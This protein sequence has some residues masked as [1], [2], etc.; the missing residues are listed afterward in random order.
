MTLT[1]LDWGIIGV[2]LLAIIV[3]GLYLSRRAAKSTDSFF[4]GGR[5]MPWWLLGTSMVA[6]TFATDTPNLVTGL[7][8]E[9]GVAG[10]WGWWAFLITGMLTAFVYARLWRR[11][12]IT[13]DIEFYELRYSGRPAAF[14]RGLRAVY[15]GLFFNV[16]VM[17]NVTLALIKYGNVLFGI[18]PVLIVLVA[19]AATVLL[20]AS[21]GLL[22]VLVTDFFLFIISMVGAIAAAWFALHHTD[23]GGLSGLMSNTLVLEKR[24]FLPDFSDPNQYVPLFMVPLLLQWWSAWYPGSEPGG[25]GYVAQRMLAAKDERNATGAVL[26]FNIAHYA[27][28]PWPWILVALASLVVFPDLASMK[29]A[30]PHVDESLIQNDLAYPAML[31]F[32]PSG[33]FGLVV[34]S[35]LAAYVSTMST[36]LN[37]GSS[38]IVNDVYGRFIAPKA[39]DHAKVQV[40]R[41]VIVLLMV[42]AALLA[43]VLESAMQAFRL[44]LSVGAGTGLL[45]FLRWFWKRINA[46]SEIAAMVFSLLVASYLEFF[47]PADLQIWQRFALTVG[48]TTLGWVLVT[49]LSPKNDPQTLEKFE[50]LIA[51]AGTKEERMKP[52]L[53]AALFA[54][55]GVY[56]LLFGTGSV[57][58]G[59]WG[60]A[61]ALLGA[62]ALCGLITARVMQTKD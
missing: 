48:L 5:S 51:G 38:Y 24:S 50:T 62:S 42:A 39:S 8:R 57:L 56:G 60:L 61:V 4:L 27:L 23:V 3:T 46:W 9:N 45:F 35:I 44:L 41:M 49:Y 28:R 1:G 17:A 47:G 29:A 33:L 6:T 19:G 11:L 37:L 22:G 30:L 31:T 25:G 40:G 32:L 34:A 54:S 36:M 43:L 18:S 59:Q 15:L 12:G 53:I 58:Y 55:L 2:I 16:L 21:G 13:T 14:L 52:A 10:N 20:C 7:V 26:L